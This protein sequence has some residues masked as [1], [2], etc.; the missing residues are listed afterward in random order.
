MQ[1]RQTLQDPG[2]WRI[3]RSRRRRHRADLA[4]KKQA[5]ARTTPTDVKPVGAVGA[6]ARSLAGCGGSLGCGAA[7]G[8]LC[9]DRPWPIYLTA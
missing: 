5:L 3:A 4:I 7:V 9:R 6:V 2:L 8:G 1:Q